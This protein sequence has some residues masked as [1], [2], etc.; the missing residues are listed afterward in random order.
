MKI[1]LRVAPDV[2]FD[3]KKWDQFVRQFES[4]EVALARISEGPQIPGG[5]FHR[6]GDAGVPTSPRERSIHEERSFQF[7]TDLVAQFKTDLI[8]GVIIASGVPQPF[9][10]RRTIP[11]DECRRVWPN[12][13]E[14][15]LL[16]PLFGYSQV[17]LEAN[18][19]RQAVNRR[20][21]QASITWLQVQ[22]A[23]KA[24]RKKEDLRRLAKEH[25]GQ[26]IPVRVFNQAYQRVYDRDRGRPRKRI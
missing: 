10:E 1:S 25:F 6:K 14:K 21:L 13:V 26:N 2:F 15:T 19:T 12:F 7:G 8:D 4:A 17:T 5:G 20:L 9:G 3:S 16:G 24:V 18:N 22:A 23:G 11:A